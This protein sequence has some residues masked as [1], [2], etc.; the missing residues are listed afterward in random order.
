MPYDVE[1]EARNLVN[2]WVDVLGLDAFGVTVTVVRHLEKNHDD[3]ECVAQCYWDFSTLNIDIHLAASVDFVS[4]PVRPS[5][6]I[7]D[8]EQT[9]LHELLHVVLAREGLELDSGA[10]R[11]VRQALER[12]IDRLA[13]ILQDARTP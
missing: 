8:L 7:V 10:P 5:E 1:Q 4:E 12:V 6:K 11:Q 2:A 9:V 13:V 3:E